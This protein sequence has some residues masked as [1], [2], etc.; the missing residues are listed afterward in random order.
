[1]KSIKTKI[2]AIVLS[3]IIG[4]SV[5]VGSFGIYWSNSAIR[6]D[7]VQ[8]LDLMADVQSNGLNTMFSDVEQSSIVLSNY[9]SEELDSIFVLTDKE[10]FARYIT[11]IENIAFYIANCTRHALSVYVRFAPE[12]TN[13]V[14]SLI[15]RRTGGKFE[16]GTLTDFPIY[17][18]DFEN[19]WYYRAR[20]F[21]CGVWTKP[22]YNDDFREY[23]VSYSVPV[24]K[25][26]KFFGVVGIDIDF[27]DMATIVNS[28]S[29]YNSGYAFLT[30]EDFVILY[31]RSIPEGTRL[32][33]QTN[34]FYQVL[35]DESST[36]V[37]EYAF[38][39]RK[40]RMI[41]KELINGMRLVVSVPAREIDKDRTKLIIMI[42]LSV[43]V[44][45]VM[46]SLFSVWMSNRLTKPLKE[47]TDS[48]NKIVAG[49]YDLNFKR[50]PHDEIGNLM[51]TFSFMAKSLKVQ[52]DYINT[53]IYIDS[54]TGAKNKRAFIDERTEIDKKIENSKQTGKKFEFGIIVFDVNNL[55][56]L[57]DNFGH[58]EGDEL[59][60]NS[61]NLISSNFSNS[62]VFRIGGDEFVA[63]ITEK[64]YENCLELLTKFR[65]EMEYLQ[66][67]KAKPSEQLSIAAG[68]AAY[69]SQKDVNFQS[70]FARADEEMYRAKIAMKGGRENV[71]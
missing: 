8:I 36:P 55:K 19:S 40:S 47:L 23:V 6:K 24:Y 69:D 30:D 35:K 60:K 67:N 58:E 43:L 34:D 54:M 2:F 68:F 53:L 4:S 14:E 56:Y 71:R 28:I 38:K 18:S 7:S 59:I 5:I 15:W 65:T 11:K 13:G 21:D 62:P 41:Y 37:Y 39:N 57:N 29:I 32:F 63:V 1:M 61:Y 45:S 70:V 31:H 20:K 44:I 26:G 52:F 9:V 50:K 64:D 12:L 27:D 10:E 48:T 66:N 33:N 16:R 25:N 22:Y 49:V 51:N 42:V 17:N 3:S 46:V